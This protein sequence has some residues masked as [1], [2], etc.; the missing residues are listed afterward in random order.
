MNFR[1]VRVVRIFL[2]EGRGD[3]ERLLRQLHDRWQV[4]GVTVYRGVAGFGDSGQVHTTRILDVS[5]E[6]PVTVEFYDSP[7]RVDT[8]LAE[9]DG[10]KPGHVVTWIAD[11]WMG[12]EA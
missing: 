8:V 2:S 6:L 4:H 1:S 5:H 9:L 12:D 7:E 3:T 11:M 10:I